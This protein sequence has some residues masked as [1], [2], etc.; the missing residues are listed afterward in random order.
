MLAS[1]ELGGRA[2]Q[3]SPAAR[4]AGVHVLCVASLYALLAGFGTAWLPAALPLAALPWVEGAGAALVGVAIGLP[5]W[6]L[7]INALFFPAMHALLTLSVPPLAYLAG[8][9]LLLVCNVGAWRSRVPLFLSSRQAAAVV[10]TLLPR[11]HGF[12]LLD[13]GSGTGSFLCNLAGVRPDGRYTGVEMAPLPL[14]LARW[15]ARRRPAL[16]VTLGDFWRQDLAGYD[17]VYAYLSPAPMARLWRKARAEMRPGSLFISNSFAVPGVPPQ[18][19]IH[20]GDR[21]RSTL[22]VWTM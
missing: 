22:Y 21:M 9:A 4:A 2:A 3:L 19:T 8:L 17:V 18:Q 10:T 5:R 14:L 7:P 16:Q 6:W 15:R 12:R 13:L 20:L 11:A 1:L